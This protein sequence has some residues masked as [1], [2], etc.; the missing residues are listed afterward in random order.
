[1][2]AFGAVII[3]AYYPRGLPN[4][5]F[6]AFQEFGLLRSAP[7]RPVARRGRPPPPD[8][9]LPLERAEPCA[10]RRGRSTV[11]TT[12]APLLEVDLEVERRQVTVEACFG[13]EACERLALFGT[14][15]AGKT[16]ILESIA[17]LTR[18]ESRHDPS[19]GE[20]GRRQAQRRGDLQARHRQVALVRQPT[21]LFPHLTVEQNVA[22]GYAAPL[23]GDGS[24]SSGK[25]RARRARRRVARH[26]PVA[27]ARRVALGRALASSFP[28]AAPRRA[29][30]GRRRRSP[31]G[32]SPVHDRDLGRAQRCRHPRHPRPHRGAGLQRPYSAIIDE[33]P[34]SS[35][36]RLAGGGPGP[37]RAA[38]WPSSSATAA[39][40]R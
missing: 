14:S 15:G 3:V 21:T 38:A 13:L 10:R 34:S 30:F 31:R 35:D 4:Q 6:I 27:N 9:R 5:I 36:G 8:P 11:S 33:R 37:A 7:L 29:P 25:P 19:R 28:R 12:T 17:G 39:S 24:A 23:P 26:C 1:M 18:F 22:Y 20:A 32:P 2:G 16:T 40:S